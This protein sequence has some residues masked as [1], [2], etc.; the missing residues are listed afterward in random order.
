M[1]HISHFHIHTLPR[2][3][4]SNERKEKKKKKKHL[5][6]YSLKISRSFI[7]TFH[8]LLSLQFVIAI[9]EWQSRDIVSRKSDNT[10]KGRGERKRSKSQLPSSPSPIKWNVNIRAH[11]RKAFLSDRVYRRIDTWPRFKMELEQFVSHFLS[12]IS[13]RLLRILASSQ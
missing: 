5:F 3:N 13:I 7:H 6:Y 1:T 2:T 10:K 8:S 9:D 4:V 12:H 11:P